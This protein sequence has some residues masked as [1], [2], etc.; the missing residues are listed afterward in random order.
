MSD[1]LNQYKCTSCGAPINY[2]AGTNNLVCEYCGERFILHEYKVDI[3]SFVVFTTVFAMILMLSQFLVCIKTYVSVMSDLD[4][5]DD[6][7]SVDR[8]LLSEII[9]LFVYG[10]MVLL[11]AMMF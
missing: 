3:N 1:N 9:L 11:F 4:E 10:L 5:D 7:C 2:S 6:G 8:S